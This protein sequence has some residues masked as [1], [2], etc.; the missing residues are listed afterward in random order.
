MS[1][2]SWAKFSHGS[3][4]PAFAGEFWI[5]IIK[6]GHFCGA[7]F[8]PGFGSCRSMLNARL[9]GRHFPDIVR[10]PPLL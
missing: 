8:N 5:K 9:R 1:A 4:K 6:F 3:R 7:I 10:T 2:R